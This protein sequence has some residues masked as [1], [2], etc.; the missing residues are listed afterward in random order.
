MCCCMGG[1]LVTQMHIS[2]FIFQHL[3]HNGKDDDGMMEDAKQ[4][5]AR[6]DYLPYPLG[7]DLLLFYTLS[8]KRLIVV[9]CGEC[10]MDC[11]VL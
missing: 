8:G 3:T 1:A 2:S 4:R 7:H 6:L 9:V 10:A 5:N 11:V